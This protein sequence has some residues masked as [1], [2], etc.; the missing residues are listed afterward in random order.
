MY[1]IKL[2]QDG[3]LADFVGGIFKLMKARKMIKQDATVSQWTQWNAHGVLGVSDFA[4]RRLFK[5]ISIDSHFW[6]SLDKEPGMDTI[7][8]AALTI[9]PKLCIL[10][11]APS[12]YAE[13][14]KKLWLKKFKMD[15][16]LIAEKYKY[17]YADKNT[18]LIDDKPQNCDDFISH[19]GIAVMVKQPWNETYKGSAKR[20][21][22]EG[23]AEWLYSIKQT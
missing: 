21:T 13:H 9:D 6:A 11:D 5:E 7:Y 12:I 3:V 4:W 23:I 18:I 10:T 19:G 2:D 20:L 15:H 1:K 16:T 8:K 17:K 22:P 14:G